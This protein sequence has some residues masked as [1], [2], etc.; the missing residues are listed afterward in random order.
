MPYVCSIK[1]SVV[2]I[3]LSFNV[4]RFHRNSFIFRRFLCWHYIL[5]QVLKQASKFPFKSLSSYRLTLYILCGEKASLFA[6]I[7]KLTRLFKLR[8]LRNCI[9]GMTR[10][11][12]WNSDN[13]I[14]I[15]KTA[16][17]LSLVRHLLFWIMFFFPSAVISSPVN[18]CI[19][20]LSGKGSQ[21]PALL[22]TASWSLALRPRCFL[23]GST[24]FTF[25][26]VGSKLC[27]KL[28]YGEYV[29]QGM[30]IPCK[31]WL[32][33]TDRNRY[34]HTLTDTMQAVEKIHL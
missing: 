19:S 7:K 30:S 21:R 6:T 34:T 20:F 8:S 25:S 12:D 3:S 26:A 5:T 22:V 17:K 31:Y 23:S 27:T 2:C 18:V 14:P 9:T 29:V 11:A 4:S 13:V 32:Q 16:N 1:L 15:V 24:Q 33:D 10:S 28:L